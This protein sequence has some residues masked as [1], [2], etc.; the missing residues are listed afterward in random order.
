MLRRGLTA[1]RIWQELCT[2]YGF[3]HGYVSMAK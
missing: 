3:A 1:Q 2:E